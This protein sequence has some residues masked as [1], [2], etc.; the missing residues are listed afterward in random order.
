[1]I[2]V[3]IIYLCIYYIILKD[4]A[5]EDLDGGR[6]QESE[7]GG[8]DIVSDTEEKQLREEA[9][10]EKEMVNLYTQISV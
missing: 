2:Y 6:H 7:E 10:Y 4:K 3:Y 5:C 8:D 9:I 1:M